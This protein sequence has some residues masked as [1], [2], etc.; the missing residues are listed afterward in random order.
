MSHHVYVQLLDASTG[1]IDGIIVA[2]GDHIA[3]SP[4]VIEIDPVLHG[5]KIELGHELPRKFYFIDGQF[6][7]RPPETL[8]Q[9]TYADLRRDTYPPMADQLDAIWK[10]MDAMDAMREQVLSVKARFPKS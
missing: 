5:D 8:P 6:V 9:N 7:Q 1:E 4:L 3:I 2:N 10:G